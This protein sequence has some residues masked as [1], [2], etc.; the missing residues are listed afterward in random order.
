MSNS[1]NYH[2]LP[3]SVNE[4]SNNAHYNLSMLYCGFFVIATAGL[5]LAIYH[6]IALNWC[7]DYPSTWPRDS[8]AIASDQKLKTVKVMELDSNVFKYKGGEDS[9]E[10]VVCLSVFE[11]G[12]DVRELVRCQH[13]FHA[14]CIDMW[15]YSHFDCPLCR[16]PVG[17]RCES[18]GVAL[19]DNSGP[20]FSDDFSV[21]V[22]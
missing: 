20:G 9:E 10:C 6:C 5:I 7:T 4:Q 3:A 14:P 17:G 15:L 11:E 2:I 8:E 22:V 13:S 18:Q 21:Q 19:V 1:P 16:A 12:E